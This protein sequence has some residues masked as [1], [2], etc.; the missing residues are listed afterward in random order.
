E[1]DSARSR[2]A[3]GRGLTAAEQAAIAALARHLPAVWHSPQSG[4]A[5]KRRIVRS[6]LEQVVVRA[7][8]SSQEVTGPL[9]WS[10][11]T[12]TAHQLTRRVRGWTQVTQ[13]A[14]VRERVAAGQAA[15]WSSGRM[16]AELNAAGYPT[17]RGHPF[18]AASVRQLVRGGGLGGPSD[19]PEP[20]A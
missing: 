17:P 14:A 7:P 4:V 10:V 16:A 18:T 3:Q 20:V 2:Q 8:A 19:P 6:L 1:E 13:A 12:V 5:E 9:H 15:G 11:G